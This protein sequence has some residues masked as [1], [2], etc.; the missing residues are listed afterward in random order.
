MPVYDWQPFLERWSRAILSAPDADYFG[1]PADAVHAGWLGY[2]PAT[3]AQIQAAEVRLGVALPPSYRAFLRVTNG[4]LH[5][6]LAVARI[7]PVEQV[8][9]FGVAHA[10]WAALWMADAAEYDPVFDEVDYAHL[11]DTL[12]ISALGD[13]AIML[14]NPTVQTSGDECEAWFF[15]SWNPGAARY[16]SFWSLLQQQLTSLTAVIQVAVRQVHPD[17][18]PDAVLT[19]LPGLLTA[20]DERRHDFAQLAGNPE[21]TRREHYAGQVEGLA[22]VLQ[23]VRAIQAGARDPKAVRTALIVLAD[24]LDAAAE[25]LESTVREGIDV[26]GMLRQLDNLAQMLS[27]KGRMS[28]A[29]RRGARAQGLREGAGVIRWYLGVG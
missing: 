25:V 26:Q 18:P 3:E 5:T 2:A 20:L 28:D 10:D 4:W 19:K 17:D 8:E 1:L 24:R 15:A 11:P 12:A 7:L 27:S 9:R 13:D 21:Q 6:G 14:L 29:I 22:H 23:E 16:E